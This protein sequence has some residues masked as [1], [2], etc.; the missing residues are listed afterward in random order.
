MKDST[1]H[2]I[3]M[4]I[5]AGFIGTIIGWAIGYNQSYA[6]ARA[7]CLT[8]CPACPVMECGT[9]PIQPKTITAADMSKIID[10]IQADCGSTQLT[11]YSTR[12]GWAVFYTY[13]KD[14]WSG[15][16]YRWI[17]DCWKGSI[18]EA[19]VEKAITKMKADCGDTF[20]TKHGIDPLN[21]WW[22]MR[23]LTNG[24]LSKTDYILLEDCW[25]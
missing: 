12:E 14:G 18:P 9:C 16:D 6:I 15:F 19:D 25:K 17:A 2:T 11:T 3:A 13:S 10:E 21:R 20:V 5:Y 8:T 1:S 22:I 4:M 24:G 7:D 23:S